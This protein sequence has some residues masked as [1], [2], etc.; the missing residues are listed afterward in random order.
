M[1]PRKVIDL[2]YFLMKDDIVG[3]MMTAKLIE[4][5]DKMNDTG[6]FERFVN[7]GAFTESE[8]QLSR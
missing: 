2:Q 1:R 3:A 5:V 4:A 6:D 8:G 7:E